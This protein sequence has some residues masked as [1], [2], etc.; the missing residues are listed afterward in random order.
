MGPKSDQGSKKF[1]VPG[2][3]LTARYAG[4]DSGDYL[5]RFLVCHSRSCGLSDFWPTTGFLTTASLHDIPLPRGRLPV[6]VIRVVSTVPR[7]LPVSPA[8]RTLRWGA[9][10]F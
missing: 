7:S 9:P 10:P 2:I 1:V 8:K 4:I 5:F 3:E 6:W